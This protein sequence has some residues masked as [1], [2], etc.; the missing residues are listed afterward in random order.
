MV[1][2][3]CMYVSG[4]SQKGEIKKGLNQAGF[5]GSVDLAIFQFQEET[6]KSLPSAGQGKCPQ[7]SQEKGVAGGRGG[8]TGKG[9][10]HGG[11]V[12]TP[13][14][15]RAQ[16][17]QEQARMVGVVGGE[18]TRGQRGGCGRWKERGMILE[19]Q[20]E[21][22]KRD[23]RRRQCVAEPKRRADKENRARK[24]RTQLRQAAGLV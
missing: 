6:R 24:A 13:T 7:S 5:P 4:D 2:A 23:G 18:R 21:L 10:G 3:G 20:W 12:H 9:R 11:P 17:S 14:R 19:V 1:N 15:Q 16:F 22:G 8:C